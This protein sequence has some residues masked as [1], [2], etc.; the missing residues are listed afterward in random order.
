MGADFEFARFYVGLT[1]DIGLSNIANDSYFSNVSNQIPGFFHYGTPRLMS[2]SLPLKN[3]KQ[4]IGS[5][6]IS[7]GYR[8]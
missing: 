1:Y 5:L 2:S 6:L 3:Y 4:R 7:V 8:F